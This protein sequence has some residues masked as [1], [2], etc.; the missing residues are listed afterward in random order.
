MKFKA[1]DLISFVLENHPNAEEILTNFGLH[2]IYCPCAQ[3]ESLE[4]ACQVHEL[5]VDELLT[6]LNA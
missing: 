6:A 2:C 3:M 4:E 1:T 5:N